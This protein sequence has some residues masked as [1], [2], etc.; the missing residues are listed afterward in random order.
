EQDDVHGRIREED[1]LLGDGALPVHT[2]V[3]Q[4]DPLAEP[5]RSGQHR[6]VDVPLASVLRLEAANEEYEADGEERITGEIE[7]IRNG[8]HRRVA[9]PDV[10]VEIEDDVADGEAQET[11]GEQVTGQLQR[12]SVQSRG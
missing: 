12:R 1:D 9:V 3:H 8:G 10:G 7:D 4:E 2:A 11:G 5:E 6:R